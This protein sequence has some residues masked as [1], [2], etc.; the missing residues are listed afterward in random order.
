MSQSRDDSQLPTDACIMCCTLWGGQGR[1][2]A[3][4]A[5]IE[6]TGMQ[7]RAPC[8]P[9]EAV[10]PAKMAQML[11]RPG[12]A[13]FQPVGRQGAPRHAQKHA[14]RCTILPCDAPIA[15]GFGAANSA[16]AAFPS[17]SPWTLDSRPSTLDPQPSTLNS[18]PSTLNSQLSTLNPIARQSLRNR[19]SLPIAR[20][21]IRA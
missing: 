1:G 3:D 15:A 11:L 20:P 9:A 6:C 17:K 10:F 14:P 7:H 12:A 16:S 5:N 19:Y 2:W 8:C 4:R 13:L 21:I 18:R